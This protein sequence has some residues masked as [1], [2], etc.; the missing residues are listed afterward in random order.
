MNTL[1]EQKLANDQAA[2]AAHADVMQ[3]IQGVGLLFYPIQ[4][5]EFTHPQWYLKLE[6]TGNFFDDR[7]ALID[8]IN[9]A[10]CMEAKYWLLGKYSMHDT[11]IAQH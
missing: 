3:H 9:S 5:L 6:D 1:N 2:Q 4:A 7:Q 10:P 11:L 8:L